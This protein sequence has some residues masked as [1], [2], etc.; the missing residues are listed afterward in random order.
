MDD[1]W[2]RDEWMMIRRAGSQGMQAGRQAGPVG[3][4]VSC[5]LGGQKFL[6]GNGGPGYHGPWSASL[7]FWEGGSTRCCWTCVVMSGLACVV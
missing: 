4:S 1:G 5:L 6:V 2:M 7:W 3:E